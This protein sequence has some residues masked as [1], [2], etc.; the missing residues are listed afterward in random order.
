MEIAT[1]IT[2]TGISEKAA[3]IYLAALQSGAVTMTDLARITGIKR[4]SVYL[5]IDTLL[6]RGLITTEKRGKKTCYRAEHPQRILQ[7][8]RTRT[9][10][11]E[12]MIPELEAMYYDPRGRPR[13]TVSEGRDAVL[14]VYEDMYAAMG[15]KGEIL[16]F[17]DIA[18]L[19]ANLPDAIDGLIER[20]KMLPPSYRLR[21]LNLESPQ[22]YEYIR[23][24]EKVKGK[25]HRFRVLDP[26]KFPYENT[27]TL[28]FENK[29]VLFSFKKEIFTV[30]IESQQ[31]ADTHR[32]MFA[33]AWEAGKEA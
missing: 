5:L 11:M 3:Q 2:T 20:I 10:E 22:T 15:R 18:S 23:K 24:L 30:V 8:L 17:T 12:R 6:G 9:R 1:L 4:P 13:V 16:F 33:A 31:I 32:A 25:H 29:T 21:E 19:H 14:A 27:D 7:T 28:I 26:K